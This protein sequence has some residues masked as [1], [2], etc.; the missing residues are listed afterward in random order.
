[1]LAIWGVI[2]DQKVESKPDSI[3]KIWKFLKN[4]SWFVRGL[5]GALPLLAFLEQILPFDKIEILRAFH[6][7]VLSWNECLGWLGGIIG[8][9]P[10]IPTVPIWLLNGLSVCS[11]LVLGNFGY[12]DSAIYWPNKLPLKKYF[13]FW[14]FGMSLILL[15]LIPGWN[16][17]GIFALIMVLL[18]IIENEISPR[19]DKIVQPLWW[20]NFI[21]FIFFAAFHKSDFLSGAP[22]VALLIPIASTIM[23]LIIF[24]RPFLRKGILFSFGLFVVFTSLYFAN[25][26]VVKSFVIEKT[27]KVLNEKN[28]NS[29]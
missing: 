22:T 6:A 15:F 1:M 18:G 2:M 7:V 23:V 21:L 20:C 27:N 24:S 26:S 19:I 9:L 17:I 11:L 25:L 10:L 28:Y 29:N 4:T 16:M 13:Y 14:F 3:S 8:C 5:L 12:S